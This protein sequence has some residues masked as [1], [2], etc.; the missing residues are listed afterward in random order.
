MRTSTGIVAALATAGLIA[1]AAAV[2]ASARPAA[3]APTIVD[4]ALA[5]NAE[6]GAFEGQLDTLIAAV[7]CNPGVLAALS[8]RGQRTV[9]APTDDAFA[10]LGLTPTTVCATPGLAGILTYH[11][12]NGRRDAGSV[13]GAASLRML[14]RDRVTVDAENV[15][16]IDGKDRVAN[17]IAVNVP[18]SNGIIH[19]ID[20][21]LLPPS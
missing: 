15:A 8:A 16:L 1:G 7:V 6:D 2:P 12:T 11:V 4:V 5:A 9:F 20:N 3:P 10:E 19:A 14:N 13:L 21:V 18:A 17:I